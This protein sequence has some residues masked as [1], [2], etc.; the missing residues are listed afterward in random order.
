MNKKTCNTEPE[1]EQ[2]IHTCHW[3]TYCHPGPPN[4]QSSHFQSMARA[5]WDTV[6]F[7]MLYDVT[8]EESSKNTNINTYFIK[9]QVL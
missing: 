1:I 3:T 8:E 6:H 9:F 7:Q 4:S 2:L 5:A